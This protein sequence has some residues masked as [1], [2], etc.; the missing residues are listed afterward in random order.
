VA[1]VSHGDVYAAL[2]LPLIFIEHANKFRYRR[3][4]IIL[5]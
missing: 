1:R 3:P 2:A 4:I 5:I